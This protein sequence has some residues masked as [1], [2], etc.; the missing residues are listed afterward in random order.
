MSIDSEEINNDFNSWDC[1]G[2]T[3]M[4]GITPAVLNF[5]FNDKDIVSTIAWAAG[6]FLVALVVWLFAALTRWRIIG[7]IVNWAGCFLTVAY[8]TFAVIMW[9]PSGEEE[10]SAEAAQPTLQSEAAAPEN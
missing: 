1:F 6:G 3:L 7:E 9:W 10:Q 2:A 8:I 4:L 5:V